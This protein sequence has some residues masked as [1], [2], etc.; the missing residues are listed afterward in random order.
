MPRHIRA[1]ALAA[2]RAGIM[3][4]RHLKRPFPDLKETGLPMKKEAGD[5][6]K[7][8]VG[9]RNGRARPRPLSAAPDRDLH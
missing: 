5:L 1:G 8:S 7:I 9:F 4:F 3:N 6:T 2:S